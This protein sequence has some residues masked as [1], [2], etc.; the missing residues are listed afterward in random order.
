MRRIEDLG[1]FL[2]NKLIASLEKGYLHAFYAIKNLQ[3]KSNMILDVGCGKGE[4][5]EKLL[6]YKVFELG[7]D[8]S[9]KNL[10]IAHSKKIALIMGDATSLPLREEVFDIVVS[11]Q[12]F[13]HVWDVRQAL[14]EQIRVLKKGG[15]LI[16]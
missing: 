14:N 13:E 6:D 3:P 8:F 4:L 5:L 7:I 12:F 15:N 16:I 9:I 2:Y 1:R 10:D 11:S